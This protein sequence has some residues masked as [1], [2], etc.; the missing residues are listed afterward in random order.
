MLG[1]AKLVAFLAARDLGRARA[2]YE[3][4][5]GLRLLVDQG[6]ALLFD[7][8]GTMLRVTE[9][10][11][12]WPAKHTVLGWEVPALRAEMQAL[13]QKGVVFERYPGLGQDDAGVCTFPSRAQVAWFKDPDG[14]TLSL[15]QFPAAEA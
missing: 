8:H 6:F 15:T 12:L 2:F 13:V 7:G 4:V 11:E 5:L 9:V 10:G 14:N 1:K 3:G